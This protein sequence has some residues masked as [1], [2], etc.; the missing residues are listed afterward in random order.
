MKGF[1]EMKKSKSH[2]FILFIWGL[3]GISIINL[4]YIM[5][6]N[7]TLEVD[8]LIAT[9]YCLMSPLLF[10]LYNGFKKVLNKR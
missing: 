5:K 7:F 2:F 10:P 8:K 6:D 4:P 3:I 9:V 1:I